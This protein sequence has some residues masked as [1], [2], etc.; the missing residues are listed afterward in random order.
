MKLIIKDKLG[1]YNILVHCVN[2]NSGAAK[3]IM[4]G[5]GFNSKILSITG[6]QR[7]GYAG[8]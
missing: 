7:E 6:L 1:N 4:H 2:T 5:F 3:V 8:K